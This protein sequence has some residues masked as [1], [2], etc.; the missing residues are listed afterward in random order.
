MPVPMTGRTRGMSSLNGPKKRGD[1]A[2]TISTKNQIRQEKGE[3]QGVAK[4]KKGDMMIMF[5]DFDLQ[6]SSIEMGPTAPA[7]GFSMPF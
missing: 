2:K 6:L 5:V 3:G 4:L 7:A 1:P